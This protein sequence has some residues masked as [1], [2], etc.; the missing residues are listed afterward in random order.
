MWQF[1]TNYVLNTTY[2]NTEKSQLVI[3]D[4][5]KIQIIVQKPF[6]DFNTLFGRSLSLFVTYFSFFF[7]FSIF[8]AF[9]SYRPQIYVSSWLLR[10]FVVIGFNKQKLGKYYNTKWQVTFR[11]VNFDTPCNFKNWKIQKNWK[12]II[13]QIIYQNRN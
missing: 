7:L 13:K 4:V 11:I 1:K 3:S 5:N 10:Y 6:H 9:F 2:M 12:N 8:F